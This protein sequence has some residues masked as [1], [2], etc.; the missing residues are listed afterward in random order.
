M[1]EP[2]FRAA[3]E[4]F[5][6]PHVTRWMNERL[7]RAQN[8]VYGEEVGIFLHEYWGPMVNYEFKDLKAGFPRAGRRM[9]YQDFS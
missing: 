7:S 2:G 1:V 3:K 6:H 5:L 4:R 9:T 8:L